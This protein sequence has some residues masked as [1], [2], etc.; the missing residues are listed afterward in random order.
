MT[1]R[2]IVQPVTDL[3]DL[4]E[5]EPVA[6]NLGGLEQARKSSAKRRRDYEDQKRAEGAV[7]TLRMTPATIERFKQMVNE[8]GV[9]QGD[10][11]DKLLTFAM[12]AVDSGALQLITR[13]KPSSKK[14]LV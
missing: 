9:L 2:A 5:N 13:Q 1:R 10:L 12:D 7:I 14:S 11:A 4:L 8:K 3:P 6:A